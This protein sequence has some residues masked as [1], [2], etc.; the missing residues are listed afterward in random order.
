MTLTSRR[1][2]L[3][4]QSAGLGWRALSSKSCVSW[5]KGRSKTEK[6]I[7]GKK[8]INEALKD[9]ICPKNTGNISKH[10]FLSSICKVNIMW[11]GVQFQLFATGVQHFDKVLKIPSAQQAAGDDSSFRVHKQSVQHCAHYCPSGPQPTTHFLHCLY[12]C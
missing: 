1:R 10:C 6:H 12:K 2:V 9:S 8:N 3:G 7:K 11:W 5:H 4:L